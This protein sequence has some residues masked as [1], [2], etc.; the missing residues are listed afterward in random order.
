ML[1]VWFSNLISKVAQTPMT[2]AGHPLIYSLDQGVIRIGEQVNIS[3]LEE[4]EDS[5]G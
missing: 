2:Y 5:C 3:V 4:A 1:C